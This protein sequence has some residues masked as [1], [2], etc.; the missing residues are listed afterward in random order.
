MSSVVSYV[1]GQLA[2]AGITTRFH[3]TPAQPIR[4]SDVILVFLTKGYL[5]KISD[6]NDG[7]IRREFFHAL[8]YPDNAIAIR[9]DNDVPLAWSH[10]SG[11]SFSCIMDM[12]NG[13]NVRHLVSVLE[14]R[15][16]GLTRQVQ[17]LSLKEQ[18]DRIEL[19]ALATK[20]STVKLIS[21]G[22]EQRTELRRTREVLLKAVFEASEVHTPT[23]F[24]ILQERLPEINSSEHQQMLA[25]T[26]RDDGNG[27]EMG[28][29]HAHIA[30]IAK[31]RF[32]E[33]AKWLGRLGR[34]GKGLVGAN[35][36]KVFGAIGEI[37]KE[38]VAGNEKY[39]YLVDELTG[40]PVRGP[41][42]PIVITTPAELV[43]KL[44]PVMQASQCYTRVCATHLTFHFNPICVH[45]MAQVSLRA[46]SIY[47]GSVGIARM[48]GVPL[49]SIPDSWKEGLWES[50][51]LL[52]HESSVTAFGAVHEKVKDGDAVAET[53]RGV[54]LRELTVFFRK[55]DAVGQYA[56]LRRIGDDNGMAMWTAVEDADV[57]MMIERRT[58]E[59]R[60]EELARDD[61]MLRLLTP[62]HEQAA[63]AHRARMC[64]PERQP[65][66]HRAPPTLRIVRPR[67][68]KERVSHALEIVGDGLRSGEHT[69]EAVDRLL[70]SIVGDESAIKKLPLINK[71]ELVEK[72]IGI[73]P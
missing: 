26:L 73:A 17:L 65:Q 56:G 25:L 18:L 27:F 71:I 23:A 72:H 7:I 12:P 15:A 43:P 24:V 40:E 41:G 21:M 29:E 33:G 19:A 47:N 70:L 61:M 34:F 10:P 66:H 53:V 62:V 42:Y 3:E 14:D 55:Y 54:S 22:K 50:V 30:E 51:E 52:K 59:R 32:D 9:F 44:L 63:S 37:F 38:L 69:R 58:A 2:A 36:D 49:P 46:M 60:K 31:A 1:S 67:M 6:G 11:S 48:F 16:Y 5:A 20:K 4:V 64:K 45:H 8:G 35:P 68:I 57:P 39:F 28:G 13:S